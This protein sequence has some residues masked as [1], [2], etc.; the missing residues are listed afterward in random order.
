VRAS[1]TLRPGLYLRYHLHVAYWLERRG[2]SVEQLLALPPA[3][4]K[5]EPQP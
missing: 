3:A 2:L 5:V 4:A 1:S